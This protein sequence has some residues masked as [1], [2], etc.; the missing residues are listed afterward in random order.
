MEG[1]RHFVYFQGTKNGSCLTSYR[2]TLMSILVYD[3]ITVEHVRSHI[4]TKLRLQ[5]TFN[6][7]QKRTPTSANF[8]IKSFSAA[9]L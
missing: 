9:G 5:S 3:L 2:I 7:T 8:A 4:G 6:R 1:R